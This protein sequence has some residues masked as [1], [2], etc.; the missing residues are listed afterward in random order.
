M[1]SNRC[2][3]VIDIRLIKIGL[4]ASDHS[5]DVHQLSEGFGETRWY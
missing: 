5:R 1:G 2:H 4:G 3:R